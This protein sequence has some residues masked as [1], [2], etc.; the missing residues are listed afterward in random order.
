MKVE[1]LWVP[2]VMF[3]GMTIIISLFFWFRYKARG[4]MQQTLRAAIEKGQELSPE[5]VESLGKPERPVKDKDLRLSLIWLAVGIGIAL[6][7][8]AMSSMEREAFVVMLGISAFPFMIGLAY[9]ILWRYSER[10]Q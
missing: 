7:G 10:A 6:F 4:Q 5:L 2:I 1:G 3:T 8:F 9:L